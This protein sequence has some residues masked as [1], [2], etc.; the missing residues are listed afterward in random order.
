MVIIFCVCA[1]H[2]QGMSIPFDSAKISP[3]DAR[4]GLQNHSLEGVPCTHLSAGYVQAS[5]VCIPSKVAD[6]F[7]ESSRLNLL[8]RSKA[9][10]VSAV[11]L[12]ETSD[13]RYEVK[14]DPNDKCCP[15][16]RYHPSTCKFHWIWESVSY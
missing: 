1:P 3:R 11:P 10:E 6:D 16:L 14:G 2:L 8:F 13:I 15:S 5:V 12:A 9:G 7:E 4:L